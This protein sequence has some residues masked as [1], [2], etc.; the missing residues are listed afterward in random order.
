MQTA[1]KGN[2]FSSFEQIIPLFRSFP[3]AACNVLKIIT[4]R[5]FVQALVC[6]FAL[7]AT[8]MF[9]VRT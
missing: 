6:R 9:Y 1:C 7:Q 4:G 2:I 5:S 3:E 8:K